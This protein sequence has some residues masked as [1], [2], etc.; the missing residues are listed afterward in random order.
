[1]DRIENYEELKERIVKWIKDY[2]NDNKIQSLVVGVSGGIDSAVVSTL[3]AETGLPT[4]PLGMPI[5]Q[6]SDQESLSDIHLAW[7]EKKYKNVKTL[8]FNLTKVFEK[9]KEALQEYSHDDLSLANSRSR[10]RMITLYQIAGKYNGIVVG[11]G[12][13]V[14]DY[15]V[16]FYT[17]YGDGGVDIA[18][19]ADIYKT[20][21]WKLGGHLGVNEKIIEASPTDGLWDDKRTDE[22]QLGASYV[23][24]EEAME[25]GT[26]PALDVLE[27][28]NRMN[29][30]KMESIPTFKL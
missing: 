12:N 21:V 22:D 15:G 11:T 20:E 9:F 27:R 17:K 14:E 28:Y 1:M 13:K 24:L 30:H 5:H 10:I 2:A 26:G 29:K 8:K 25:Y 23:D 18:P 16:G 4:F 6:D 19:I 3:C 7:L